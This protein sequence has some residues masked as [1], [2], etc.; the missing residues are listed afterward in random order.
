MNFINQ[1][2]IK[3]AKKI[4]KIQDPNRFF[5]TFFVHIFVKQKKKE[6]F[7]QF[8]VNNPKII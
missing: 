8:P 7:Q 3:Y 2:P 5:F 4:I 6:V 1:D